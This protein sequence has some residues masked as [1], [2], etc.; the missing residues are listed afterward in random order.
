MSLLGGA[1]VA[2]AALLWQASH[3]ASW[4]VL[5]AC[6]IT[7]S[8]TANTLFSLLHEA[9]HGIL[10]PNRQINE[11]GGRF[12]AAFFPTGLT[13]QRAF[14]FTHHRNNRTETEQFDIVHEGDAL[15]LKKAQWYSL[16]T[17]VYC[18]SADFDDFQY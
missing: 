12:A 14:H 1:A 9:V 3:T 17:G 7:F 6:A 11:W 2:S 18:L 5:A 16:L 4:L 8:F 10:S 13:V 15:W